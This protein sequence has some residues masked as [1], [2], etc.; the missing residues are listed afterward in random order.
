MAMN[1]LNKYQTI[2]LSLSTDQ[3]NIKIFWWLETKET[4]HIGGH[5]LGV[6]G[7]MRVMDQ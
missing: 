6:G 3:S 4:R 2:M 1:C 7:G 5:G